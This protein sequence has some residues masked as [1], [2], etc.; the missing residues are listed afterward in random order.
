MLAHIQ[1][2]SELLK[3]DM[4]LKESEVHELFQDLINH[5]IEKKTK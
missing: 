1:I 5:Y 3:N 2:E 4:H